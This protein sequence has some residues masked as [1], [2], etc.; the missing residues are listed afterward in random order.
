MFDDATL[1]R[2]RRRVSLLKGQFTE[3]LAAFE[4]AGLLSGPSVYFHRRTLEHLRKHESAADALRDDIY[5]EALYATLT[6]WGLHRM[7]PGNARLLD[8]G[9]IRRNLLRNSDLIRELEPYRIS[10]FGSV[11]IEQVTSKLC[12]LLERLRVSQARTFLVSN[13][14]ALHHLL[15]S[16]VPPVDNEYTLGFFFHS[17]ILDG[18]N[19]EEVFRTIFPYFHELARENADVIR[20]AIGRGFMN[21]SETKI[22]DNAI[23]GYSLQHYV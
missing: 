15:P 5:V 23:V 18:D 4:R 3:S 17:M 21:T 14:K 19:D 10:D 11:T 7:D 20:G 6:A 9:D 12:T 2:L 22:I 1:E 8:L 16:L 13:T